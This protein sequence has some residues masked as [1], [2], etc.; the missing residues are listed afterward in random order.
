MKCLI[1]EDDFVSRK[2]LQ[3]ALSPYAEC[4][5]AVD[6]QEAIDACN[7]TWE[8]N[9][10]YDF[11][12]LDIMMPNVDGQEALQK[13]RS[14]EKERGIKEKDGIK[15]IMTT[16]LDD[17]KNVVQAYYEGGANAY[18]TKPYDNQKLMH[19]LKDLELI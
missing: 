14:M 5:V 10:P 13:I 9:E 17:P 4:H 8:E 11:I 7:M 6:G 3:K 12:L 16:A 2:V 19:T 15:I 1:V 18:L